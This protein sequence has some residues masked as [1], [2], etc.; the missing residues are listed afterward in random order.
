MLVL[1]LT[2]GSLPPS[3]YFLLNSNDYSDKVSTIYLIKYANI[4]I[5]ILII[6][7]YYIT[8]ITHTIIIIQYYVF[9]ISIQSTII[10]GTHRTYIICYHIMILFICPLTIQS[11]KKILCCNIYLLNKSTLKKLFKKIEKLFSLSNNM[12][13][14]IYFPNNNNI[15]V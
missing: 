5:I 12:G 14:V 9:N 7:Q 8:A 4:I 1:R 6:Y 15:F 2:W 11:T 13:T 10:V 3:H